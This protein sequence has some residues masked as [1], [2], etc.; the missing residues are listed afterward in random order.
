MITTTTTIAPRITVT[1][2]MNNSSY[3]VEMI[4]FKLHMKMS[5]AMYMKKM[6]KT[7]TCYIITIIT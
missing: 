2:L 5:L 1:F 7:K 3:L 4:I 6:T